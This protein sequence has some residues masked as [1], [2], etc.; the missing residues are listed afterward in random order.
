MEAEDRHQQ[1]ISTADYERAAEL[2]LEPGAYHY[3]AGGAGDEITLRENVAAWQRFALAPRM[4]VGVGDVNTGVTV[5]GRDLP[6]PLIVG[7]TAFQLLA[8]PEAEIATARAASR[9]ATTM[10]LSTLATTSVAALAQAVPDARRWF[11]LYI[12]RDRGVSRELVRTAEEHGYEALVL[13][14]DVPVIGVRERELRARLEPA[15]LERLTEAVAAVRRRV[16]T[17]SDFTT[18]FDPTVTWS[19]VE[20]LAAST[21]L[22]LLR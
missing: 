9:T 13:T 6:H 5:L 7:P 12:F 19:D 18:Q 21:R 20:E 17:P 16:S 2:V 11:Q 8:H 14:V 4:L 15:T 22:P 10:C 3:I 1:L